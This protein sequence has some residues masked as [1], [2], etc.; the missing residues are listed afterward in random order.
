MV[1]EQAKSMPFY[2]NAECAKCGA[3]LAKG[4][5]WIANNEISKV[6]VCESCYRKGFGV[7]DELK[8]HPHTHC[9]FCGAYN[10]DDLSGYAGERACHV[11]GHGGQGE[12]RLPIMASDSWERD[13]FGQFLLRLFHIWVKESV[14]DGAHHTGSGG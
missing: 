12:G 2:G 5:Y 9:C 1:D 7:A 13:T 8:P 14:R 6:A 4:C 11:C 3:S 10:L